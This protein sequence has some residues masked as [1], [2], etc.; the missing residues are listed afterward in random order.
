MRHVE[1]ETSGGSGLKLYW[2]G[3]LPDTDPK[4]IVFIAHGLAEH[5]GRYAHVGSALADR[6]YAVYAID[7]RG[8][9]R[10]EGQRSQIDSVGQTVADLHAFTAVM[11]DHHPGLP[12]FLLGHSMGGAI[13]FAYA[14]E[15][16]DQLAGLILSAPALVIEDVSPVTV[17]VGKVL[18]RIAPG[19]GV[20]QLDSGAVSRDPEVVRAY[21]TDPLNF[22]GKVPARTAAEIL[23]VSKAAPARLP[24]LRVPLLVFQGSADRLVS[25]KAAPLVHARAGSADKTLKVYEGLYHETMNEPERDEV[26]AL[27][28]D[29]LDSRMSSRQGTAPPGH[30][31]S[32]TPS[33]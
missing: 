31:R 16:Q 14:L 18:A 25:P 30:D 8:H 24:E 11:R 32:T 22:R 27:V 15:H 23:A 4:A 28:G 6:G 5:G 2:Q 9:G 29:W 33:G 12:L 20:L 19:V 3:W 21:D 26:I 1:N 10:S 13:A 7:H 17:T